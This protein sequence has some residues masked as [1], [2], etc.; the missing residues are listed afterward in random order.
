[1][2]PT[3][4]LTP[5]LTRLAKY[6]GREQMLNPSIFN[7]R[8]VRAARLP[9]AN[10][11]A[12]AAALAAALEVLAASCNGGVAGEGPRLFSA[13][14][15][16]AMRAE[17]RPVADGPG[18]GGA[19]GGGDG[20]GGTDAASVGVGVSP[21]PDPDPNG[22]GALLDNAGAAFGLGVQVSK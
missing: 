10:G 18:H 3:L 12:S 15:V 13:A 22:G 21:N 4:T 2:T 19:G 16:D 11:H 20:G 14:R 7:M 9:S 6:K 17:Q 8:K 1:M 5:T